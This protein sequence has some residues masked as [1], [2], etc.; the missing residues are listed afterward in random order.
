MRRCSPHGPEA[1]ELHQTHLDTRSRVAPPVPVVYPSAPAC[2]CGVPECPR[3]YLWCTRVPPPVPV[4]YLSAPALGQ[5]GAPVAVELT[6]EGGVSD[7]LPLPGAGVAHRGADGEGV[8]NHQGVGGGARLHI[9]AL[10]V[11]FWGN[12]SWEQLARLSIKLQHYPEAPGACSITQKPPGHAALP[13][14]P[15]GMQHYPEAPGACSTL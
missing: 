9:S 4:V 7:Q 6:G 1:I 15:R 11:G 8:A 3:L 10:L 12:M 5:R 13:R 14:S 2:T